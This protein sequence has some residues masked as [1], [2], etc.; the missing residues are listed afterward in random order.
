MKK[1]LL[2]VALVALLVVA[3]GC[4]SSTSSTSS[5]SAKP[6]TTES[7]TDKRPEE[8]MKLTSTAFTDGGTI[9][10]RFAQTGIIGGENVSIPLA[11]DEVP[12]KTKSFALVMID[13]DASDR[14]HWAVIN[15]P[16][17]TTSFVENA[18]NVGM[19]SIGAIELLNTSGNAR[20][21]GPKPPS[22]GGVHHYE[23]TIYALKTAAVTVAGQPTAAD[24]EK[25]VKAQ[26]LAMGRITGLFEN[27]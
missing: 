9:P 11:W 15:I 27:K 25:A 24:F 2:P 3:A 16:P 13:R 17:S 7:T 21:D 20:Y 12:D 18:T 8:T 1:L 4:M 14:V 19:T 10:V 23:I 6:V 22:G 26:A 5:S